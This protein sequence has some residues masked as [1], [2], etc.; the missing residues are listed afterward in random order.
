MKRLLLLQGGGLVIQRNL[1]PCCVLQECCSW[2]VNHPRLHNTAEKTT[3][4]NPFSI[5]EVQ[6]NGN[7]STCMAGCAC[8]CVR[9]RVRACLC[10]PGSPLLLRIPSNLIKN[11]IRILMPKGWG[12]LWNTVNRSV[13]AECN[14]CH[15]NKSWNL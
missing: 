3:H 4:G 10:V 6:S 5:V 12:K 7:P 14:H 1:V 11:T 2:P 8:A 15:G 13:W 9:V